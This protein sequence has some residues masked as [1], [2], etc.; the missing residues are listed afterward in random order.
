MYSKY[1]FLLGARSLV[2]AP[3]TEIK[4]PGTT[5][6]YF[7]RLLSVP[8]SY[9]LETERIQVYLFYNSMILLKKIDSNYISR[10]FISNFAKIFQSY[11]IHDISNKDVRDLVLDFFN[12]SSEYQKYEH[13]IVK[14][15]VPYY[16]QLVRGIPGNEY[17]L[18]NQAVNNGTVIIP[19]TQFVKILRMLLEQILFKRI[20]DMN[21]VDNIEVDESW[22]DTIR[23]Q[24]KKYEIVNNPTVTTPGIMPPCFQYMI[25]KAHTEHHLNHIE[26]VALGIYLKSKNYSD[27]Y[28]LDIYKDLSDYKEK[29]TMYQLNRLD[30]Y[31]TYGCEKM[32][33]ENICKKND[34]KLN[35]CCKINTPYHY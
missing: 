24:Y 5:Y 32:E 12:I 25:Q 23:N 8:S 35:R 21:P 2:S 34:D 6:S 31:K 13:E 30:K 16:L 26:R 29:V 18:I 33:T 20:Q 1:P 17:K 22:I 7:N 28:I 14:M 3:Y 11:F 27:D 4:Y 19:N 10:K 15:S 9:Q